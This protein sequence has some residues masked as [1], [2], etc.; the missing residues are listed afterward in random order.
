MI[1]RLDVSKLPQEHINGSAFCYDG[2][3]I[4]PR[5]I[6]DYEIILIVQGEMEFKVGDERLVIKEKEYIFLLPDVEHTMIRATTNCNYY[7][8]HFDA[9]AV[10]P[11]SQD[12]GA[13]MNDSTSRGSAY[14]YQTAKL[15]MEF[16]SLVK[17]FNEMPQVKRMF[18]NAKSLALSGL[19]LELLAI[20]TETTLVSEGIKGNSQ[21]E[22][23]A[24][25]IE[26]VYLIH[27]NLGA[28]MSVED[29]AQVF[30]VTP[31]YFI[32]KFKEEMGV[33]PLQYINYW[34]IEQAKN[35]IRMDSASFEQICYQLHWETPHY[36][37]KIFKKM[38]GMTPGQYKKAYKSR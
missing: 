11:V 24:M 37:S 28:K 7:Y 9:G 8:V 31:Q 20:I 1:Y 26:A 33:T 5:K 21:K 10:S 22:L 29:L 2:W 34:K 4:K 16:D 30:D 12:I 3:N 13:I 15:A 23:N 17:I 35:M 36:F 25:M 18:P 14:L 38:T 6:K 19:V 32:R 27:H